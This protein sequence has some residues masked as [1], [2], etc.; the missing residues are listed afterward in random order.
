MILPPVRKF[1]SP[2]S[3]YEV[4][5]TRS[6]AGNNDPS[7]NR[8]NLLS[9]N[10][11]N[12]TQQFDIGCIYFSRSVLYSVWWENCIS[13]Q[14]ADC[15]SLPQKQRQNLCDAGIMSR[16]SCSYLKQFHHT[17]L[18]TLVF[19]KLISNRSLCVFLLF[20]PNHPSNF[21][22]SVFTACATSTWVGNAPACLSRLRN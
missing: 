5:L 2:D 6:Q 18:F 3:E 4:L 19:L 14:A 11:N 16:N 21:L 1:N 12:K 20:F 8:H 15:A 13:R 10:G 22:C 17:N 9:R 7:R